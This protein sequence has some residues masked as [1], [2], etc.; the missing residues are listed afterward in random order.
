MD[1]SKTVLGIEFGSTR[2][3][4]VLIDEYHIPIAY[5]EC[6]W[7]NELI[8]GIWTYSTEAIHTGLQCCYASLKKDI[9]N[10]FNTVLSEV[11][12]IGISGMMH[13][14]L[15][16]DKQGK[17]LTEFRTWRNT[18]TGEAASKLTDLFGYNIPQRWSIAHLY[19]AILNGEKHLHKL[20]FLTTLSGYVHWRLTGERVV[21]IG[22]AS[23]MFPIDSQ[24]LN[25]DE[26]M[27]YKF[28]LKAK[29]DIYTWELS[30]IL[31]KILLAGENA[32]KLTKEGALLIDPEGDL[33]C[34]IPFAPPEGD[35]GTGMVATNSVALG[36]GNVSAGTS[37]FSMLVVDK[38]I[39]KRKEVDMVT[40]PE[41]LPV[42]MVHCNNC[43]S[44][45][46]SW[47][48]LFCEFAREVDCKIDK[49]KLYNLLFEKALQGDSDCGNLLSYN[50]LSGEEIAGVYSG[51]P[52]FLRKPNSKF[53][54]SNFMR[55]HLF[56]AIATLKIGLDIL[57]NEEKIEVK[58]LCAHG[59]YFKNQKVG[60]LFLSAATKCAVMVRETAGEGGPYGMCLL[61]ACML[62]KEK[63]VSL[64]DYLQNSVFY[65]HTKVSTFWAGKEDIAEFDAFLSR[66]K[67]ALKIE[68]MAAELFS[69][70]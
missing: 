68:R 8:N 43:T 30:D 28:E 60:P 7:E 54:L 49:N 70:E 6:L 64:A 44:D 36:T 31:P 17:Q 55:T 37:A 20:D 16:F 34:G 3:K 40:T 65:D 52:L 45:I 33:R 18:V 15:P 58:S 50:Y 46:N 21:G 41:G 62:N 27:L 67:S 48:N 9:K 26:D 19:Q 59:G 24:I 14:Y 4:A 5:G 13:G 38:P 29:P 53:T 1:F 2:I 25:Y 22:E 23:G 61:T 11:G 63:G 10:K 32:G 39:I 51:A 66:Y 57:I 42:A 12:A 56:S 35:A 69:E 47:I